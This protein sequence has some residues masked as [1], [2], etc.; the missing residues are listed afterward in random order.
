[1]ARTFGLCNVRTVTHQPVI[2][3][4]PHRT[5]PLTGW[6]RTA[7]RLPAEMF[8]V[9]LGPLFRGRSLLLVH[10]GQ[11]SGPAR[12]T[13]VE[14]VESTFVDGRRSW[15]VVRGAGPGAGWYR[16]LLRTP[17]ATVQAGRRFHVVTARFLK[18][19]EGGELMARYAP[20]HPRIARRLCAGLGLPVGRGADGYRRVGAAIP[21]VRLVEDARAPRPRPPGG[22]LRTAHR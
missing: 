15:T 14:V 9:G 3:S 16:N 8:R 12:R 20:R 11:A 13:A 18:P 5:A 1:M 19:P 4:G 7:A 6:R 21:F 17:R 10:T 22:P 2:P